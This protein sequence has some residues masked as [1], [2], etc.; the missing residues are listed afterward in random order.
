MSASSRPLFTFVIPTRDRPE[1]AALAV[2]G[3]NRQSFRDFEVILSDNALRRHFE[4]DPRIFDGERFRYVRPPKSAWMTDHW[5]F[6]VGLARGRYVGVLGDKSVLAP[7]ALEQVAAEIMT[8]SPDAVS[9]R[10]GVFQ[11]RGSDLGGPGVVAINPASDPRPAKVRAADALDYLLATYLDPKFEADH[12]LE[13]RGS[14]YHGV[15]SAGLLDAMKSRFGRIFRFYAPDLNA[16]CAAMQVAREVISIPRSLELV[17]TGPSNGVAVGAKVAH[18][19]GTQDE[20]ATGDSGAAPPL[21]PGVSA[22]IAHLLASDLVAVSGRTL[23]PEQWMEL[24]RRTA[25]DLYHVEGWPYRSLRQ[26][27]LLALWTSAERFGPE[28]RGRLRREWWNVRR[29][30]ARAWLAGQLRRHLGARVH[31]FRR[32]IARRDAHFERRQV[33]HLF[34]ALETTA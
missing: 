26:A 13:I 31:D 12:Q 33:E 25:F 29:G 10:V 34:A 20:A 15:Y 19:W 11:P 8:N 28:L 23:E 9:W 3:L 24:H 1:F 21:I 30:K 7:S 5:E 27:Q 2:Q 16:Q 4:P 22:S 32:V 17:L 6:A 14:I 18:I